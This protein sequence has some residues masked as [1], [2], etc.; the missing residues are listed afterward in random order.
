MGDGLCQRHNSKKIR[1]SLRLIQKKERK[2]LS[3]NWEEAR[4][5][6]SF[7]A[8]IITVSKMR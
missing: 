7:L 1:A 4:E 5:E 6:C 2:H 8:T 3:K